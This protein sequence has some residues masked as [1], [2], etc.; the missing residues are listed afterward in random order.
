[1][2][3]LKSLGFDVEVFS[4]WGFPYD[5]RDY[6]GG[7]LESL[8]YDHSGIRYTLD[9]DAQGMSVIR[10]EDYIFSAADSLL[11]SAL[12]FNPSIIYAASDHSIGLASALVASKLSI[13]FVYEMRGLWAYSRSANNPNF[14]GSSKFNLMMRLE[15]QCAR[16][17][18]RLFVI[19][20]AL[21]EMAISWGID[22]GKIEVIPNGI[23]P[24]HTGTTINTEEGPMGNTKELVVGYVGAIVPFE[25]LD[26]L[27]DTAELL[28]SE[29]ANEGIKFLIVGDGTQKQEIIDLV[30]GKGLSDHFEFTGKVPH[31]EIR[32]FYRRMDVVVIPRKSVMVA[33]I[34]PALKPLEAMKHGKLVV[35]SNVSPNQQLIRQMN[36]GMLFQK[37]SSES[38]AKVIMEIKNNPEKLEIGRVSRDWV[39]ENRLW[40]DLMKGPAKSC[41]RLMLPKIFDSPTPRTREAIG[42]IR[43]ILNDKEKSSKTTD[44]EFKMS[45]NLL[46]KDRERKNSFLAFLRELG[47]INP[48]QALAFGK[49]HIEEWGDRRS[50]SSMK[51][52][53]EKTGKMSLLT[54]I[55]AKMIK[56]E[57]RK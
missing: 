6:Q 47:S 14:F 28:L 43:M 15:I 16:S 49:I 53:A 20:E 31:E 44:D 9:P 42:L 32:S 2:S 38:L 3:S 22:P 52:Y 56:S 54:E 25:G 1:M 41:A 4:R 21:K 40:N 26:L 55:E 17:A 51:K 35:C 29:R 45:L 19:S 30:I 39:Y 57:N 12:N 8:T 11:E 27:V 23:N 13:P 50:I 7:E 5:R 10:D 34:V 48:E 24:D 37:G 33:E 36:N 18:D 46:S